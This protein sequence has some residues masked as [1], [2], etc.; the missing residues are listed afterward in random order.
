LTPIALLL[1]LLAASR[2]KGE[3]PEARLARAA[4][5]GEVI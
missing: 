2:L 3:T 1:L 5:A 4:A